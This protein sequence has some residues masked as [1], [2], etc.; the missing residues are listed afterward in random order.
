LRGWFNQWLER[1]GQATTA[2][3]LSE[4]LV[5]AIADAGFD[6]IACGEIDIE[7]SRRSTFFVNTWP[8]D[9]LDFYRQERLIECDP[10][11]A[12]MK[13]TA[14]PFAWSDLSF[15][16][17]RERQVLKAVQEFGW[18][19]GLAVPI[20]RGGSRFG[21]VSLASRAKVPDGE[22]RRLV[23]GFLTLAYERLRGAV[24][25]VDAQAN[26]A[27]LT[28]REIDCLRLVAKGL[29]DGEIGLELGISAATAHEYIERAK[30]RL[31]ARN[32]PHAIAIA[33]GLHLLS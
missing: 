5:S 12:Q 7:E 11:V 33:A 4:M 30:K 6:C 17:P 13:L 29:P 9:W 22:D 23:V 32:R 8:A 20:P 14:H 16:D 31:G 26:N 1:L 28:S 15:A 24:S 18:I 3:E 10:L 27:G 2:A 21:L 19:D 25:R